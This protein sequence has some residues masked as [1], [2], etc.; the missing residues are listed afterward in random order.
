MSRIE[1]KEPLAKRQ[2]PAVVFG[3]ICV[4]IGLATFKLLLDDLFLA[5]S[6]ADYVEAEL[7]ITKYHFVLDEGFGTPGRASRGI[8]HTPNQI[9]GVIHPGKI[10]IATNDRDIQLAYFDNSRQVLVKQIRPIDVEGKRIPVLYRPGEEQRRRWYQPAKVLTASPAKPITIA[11][12]VVLVLTMLILTVKCFRYSRPAPKAGEPRP[13][14]PTWTLECLGATILLW[15]PFLL[16]A[17]VSTKGASIDQDG[18]ER[19]WSPVEWVYRL[20]P[21]SLFAIFTLGVTIYTLYAV[22]YRIRAGAR[23]DQ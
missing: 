8:V 12:E 10:A 13:H 20:L 3:A 23:D 6:L 18:K 17:M 4:V 15:P 19:L 14:W 5:Y 22:I 7:E 21:I 2:Y 9:D 1:R 11:I 16:L